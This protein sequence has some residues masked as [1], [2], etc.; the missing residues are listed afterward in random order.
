MKFS[1]INPFIRNAQIVKFLPRDHAVC[2]Y[3]CRLFYLLNGCMTVAADG[4]EFQMQSN[5]FIL[6]KEATVYRLLTDRPIELLI[7]NFDM[8]REGAWHTDS[9]RPINASEFRPEKVFA[10]TEF[11]DIE[12]FSAPRLVKNA[13]AFKEQLVAIVNEFSSQ[14]KYYELRASGLFKATIIDVIRT[15]QDPGAADDR[16]I[17]RILEYVRENLSTPLT[18]DSIGRACGYHPNYINRL[19]AE[20]TGTTLKQYILSLR[21]EKAATLLQYSDISINELSELC[22]FSGATY[23]SAAFRRHTGMTPSQF[24][25]NGTVR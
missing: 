16:K 24:R 20:S 8:S 19:I 3:D 12:L 11:E 10:K 17:R 25:H 13:T 7:L 21:M 9:I 4:T 1:E 5:S 23:F 22:G 2:A 6:F 15:L 14:C 18:N